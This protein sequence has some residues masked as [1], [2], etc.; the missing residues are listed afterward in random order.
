MLRTTYCVTCCLSP[1]CTFWLAVWCAGSCVTVYP[2]PRRFATLHT[3]TGTTFSCSAPRIARVGEHYQS[4]PVGS[5][6]LVP[7]SNVI[8]RT[9]AYKTKLAPTSDNVCGLHDRF[10]PVPPHSAL[11]SDPYHAAPVQMGPPTEVMEEELVRWWQGRIVYQHNDVIVVD[12]PAGLPCQPV[13]SN[14]RCA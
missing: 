4:R 9:K 3:R 5:A 10:A 8:V 2:C 14:S 13:G 1:K 7:S 6:E 11:A 12:K